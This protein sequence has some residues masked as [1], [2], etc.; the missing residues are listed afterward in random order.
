MQQFIST[1]S[2]GR[3]KKMRQCYFKM[4]RPY[5]DDL[6]WRM[7]Y[8]RIFYERSYEEIASQLFV[9]PKTVSREVA[10]FLNMGDVKLYY[11]GRPTG[12]VTLFSHEEY[13][14]YYGLYTSNAANTV[15]WDRKSYYIL[16][17]YWFCIWRR[18]VVPNRLQAWNNA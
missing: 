17:I 5:A 15:T 11:L 14:H 18:D 2:P 7:M 1:I 3:V 10:T 12:S 4:P 16:Y 8:Q 13:M 9:C 6:K